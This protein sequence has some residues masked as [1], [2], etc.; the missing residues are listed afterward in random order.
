MSDQNPR[1]LAALHR[2]NVGPEWTRAE[3]VDLSKEADRL[4]EQRDEAIR[5]LMQTHW[6]DQPGIDT[7]SVHP[8]CE[9]CRFLAAHPV[10][11]SRPDVAPQPEDG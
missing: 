1:T 7:F 6:L 8:D 10:T 5:L 11:A 2:Y 9:S 4:Q 3:V